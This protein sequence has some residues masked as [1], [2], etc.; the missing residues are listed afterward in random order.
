[1]Q[2]IIDRG[3]DRVPRVITSRILTS[4]KGIG[5]TKKLLRLLNGTSDNQFI[6]SIDST[7]ASLTI[8]AWT[9]LRLEDLSCGKMCF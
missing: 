4:R 1:M 7:L 6:F 5:K 8:L 3:K 9:A 2:T